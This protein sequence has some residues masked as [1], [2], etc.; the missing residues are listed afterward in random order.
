MENKKQY[1]ILCGAENNL[2]AKFCCK[3]GESLNQKDD[4][5]QTYAK[6][7]VKDKVTDEIK[8]KATDSLL[9]ML[10]KFLNSKAYGIIL[11]LS[12][13]AGATGMMAGGSGVK[14]FSNNVPGM[15]KDG[16]IYAMNLSGMEN[17][18]VYGGIGIYPI[19]DSAGNISMIY[20]AGTTHFSMYTDLAVT[21][22]NGKKLISERIQEDERGAR[23][24]CYVVE[25]LNANIE[26]VPKAVDGSDTYDG[27]SEIILG[28]DYGIRKLSEYGKEQLEKVTEYHDNGNLKYQY[29]ITHTI[30]ADKGDVYGNHEMHYDELGRLVLETEDNSVE[31]RRHE[32]TYYDNGDILKL[33]RENNL[34]TSE[35]LED[36][37]GNCLRRVTYLNP[38]E[39]G[40]TDEYTY[41]ENGQLK[42]ESQYGRGS[43][44]EDMLSSYYEYYEDGSKKLTQSFTDNGNVYSESVYNQDGTGQAFKYTYNSDGTRYADT[45]YD[46][47]VN[48][49]GNQM[50]TKETLYR[51]DGSVWHMYTYDDNGNRVLVE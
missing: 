12:V 51:A 35:W 49:H 14:E 2:T 15:F 45:V 7:K 24:F 50:I 31:T 48:E 6:E 16:T 13:V 40:Y 22:S 19:R 20:L 8:S 33:R 23:Q 30:Y 37:N 29:F 25:D 26:I 18:G 46:F 39:I 27:K 38:G 1:C 9:D 43:V 17:L 11:S 10:K 5:L 3:C 32:V 21:G 34:Q 47:Y 42:T 44:A 28:T 4:N 41:Y 36:A